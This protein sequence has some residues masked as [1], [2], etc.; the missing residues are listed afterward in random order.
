[1][2]KNTF[3][4][5]LALS[6][7]A[8]AAPGHRMGSSPEVTDVEITPITSELL[9]AQA[10]SRQRVPAGLAAIAPE[11]WDPY[12]YR[13]GPGDILNIT[14]W[15]H[16]ELTIPAGEF[17]STEEAGHLVAEDGTIFYPYAGRVEVA[18]KLT[19]EVREILTR[20][21]SRTIQ[22]PQLE[23]RV[24]AFRS[25]KCYVVGEV[26][27]PGPEPITDVPLTIVDAISRAGRAT[28]EADLAH[29]TLTRGDKT[30]DINLVN[31]YRHGDLAGNRL[32]QHGDVLR[33][34]NRNL[35][36]VY[37]MGEVVSPR[38]VPMRDGTL[39]LAEAITGRGGVSA[40][41]SNPHYIYVIRGTARHPKIYNLDGKSPVGFLLAQQF[42]LEPHDVVYVESAQ[43]S[44]W[45]RV[46]DQLLP[47]STVLR[48]T[49]SVGGF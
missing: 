32:L 34:P 30:I 31:I 23:V 9:V 13:I 33:I 43:V 11:S 26:G 41:T 15:D 38:P 29:A 22:N 5:C 48:D 28:G 8:C 19:H 7:A 3:V 44:R 10:A 24:A 18:G 37:V 12:Q 36:Q 21:I 47:T 46:L 2:T 25:Q 40:L 14:V 49:A 6:L 17:R 42:E 16:P 35:R 39:T 1:M 20:K 27:T 45:N 4:C